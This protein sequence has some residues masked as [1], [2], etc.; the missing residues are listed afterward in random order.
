MSERSE[1]MGEFKPAL[2]SSKQQWHG[3]KCLKC[4]TEYY[5]NGRVLFYRVPGFIGKCAKCKNEMSQFDCRPEK[6]IN[7]N[8]GV[9]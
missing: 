2:D 8:Q 1:Y 5:E 9:R 6:F 4:E 3:H 7:T